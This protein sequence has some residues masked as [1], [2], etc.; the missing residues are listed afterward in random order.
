M[1]LNS[2]RVVTVFI[3]QNIFVKFVLSGHI[4]RVECIKYYYI[5]IVDIIKM[6]RRSRHPSAAVKAANAITTI[7]SDMPLSGYLNARG[8]KDMKS[9]GFTSDADSDSDSDREWKR[10][11]EEKRRRERAKQKLVGFVSGQ[12]CRAGGGVTNANDESSADTADVAELVNILQRGRSEGG[13]IL[14]RGLTEAPPLT[15]GLSVATQHSTGGGALPPIPGALPLMPQSS[16]PVLR[17]G[18]SETAKLALDFMRKKKKEENAA[19]LALV[20][21]G[22][23]MERRCVY[24]AF[25]RAK[26]FGVVLVGAS[27]RPGVNSH[28]VMQALLAQGIDVVPVSDA[29]ANNILGRRVHESVTVCAKEHKNKVVCICALGRPTE[30]EQVLKDAILAGYQCVWLQLTMFASLE[31]R[32]LAE[33]KKITLVENRCMRLD[34]VNPTF[35]QPPED[36]VSAVRKNTLYSPRNKPLSPKS[37][38]AANSPLKQQKSPAMTE[39]SAT[40]A[41]GSPS[42]PDLNASPTDEGGDKPQAGG[43]KARF[44]KLKLQ[45]KAQSAQN[46][47]EGASAT[48]NAKADENDITTGDIFRHIVREKVIKPTRPKETAFEA[49]LKSPGFLGLQKLIREESEA[50]PAARKK[51]VEVEGH[52]LP[53]EAVPVQPEL[54]RRRAAEREAAKKKRNLGVFTEEDFEQEEEEA[55]KDAQQHKIRFVG[56]DIVVGADLARRQ[57]SGGSLSRGSGTMRMVSVGT[58]KLG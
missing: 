23:V 41:A 20:K 52:V 37:A 48:A 34:S 17:R 28:T 55:R 36:S 29:A 30:H 22:V 38:G 50:G 53:K 16:E 46:S 40:T 13:S 24:D 11:E 3:I 8:E 54:E 4:S 44:A 19:R 35:K 15:R 45:I 39:C 58:S 5:F 56:S 21:E 27:A 49:L 42:S 25:Q 7:P 26:Q 2:I 10:F 32:R 18:K 47:P 33:R 14:T 1:S 51:A 57:K 12:G 31:G 6:P 9:V 43:L